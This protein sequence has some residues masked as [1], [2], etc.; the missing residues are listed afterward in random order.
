[1]DWDKIYDL[2]DSHGYPVDCDLK[3]FWL[4]VDNAVEVRRIANCCSNLLLE[5]IH[6]FDFYMQLEI[7]RITA[8]LKD[9]QDVVDISIARR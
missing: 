1:M 3:V 6:L 7:S 5:D 9:A 2:L 4:C 8:D